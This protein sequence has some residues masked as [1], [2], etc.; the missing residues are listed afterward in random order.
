MYRRRNDKKRRWHKAIIP[1]FN[2]IF[3]HAWR[4]FLSKEANDLLSGTN[5]TTISYDRTGLFP[6]N[7]K[8]DAWE[9]AIGTL[10]IHYK[11]SGKK[12]ECKGWEIQLI[13]LNEG[14]NLLNKTEEMNLLR[15]YCCDDKEGEVESAQASK[16]ILVVAKLRGDGILGRWRAKRDE[17]ICEQKFDEA[18]RLQPNDIQIDDEGDK[19][20]L[21]I[22][23]FVEATSDLP[24]P[25]EITEEEKIQ[26]TTY[27]I[28]NNTSAG[29]GAVWVECLMRSAKSRTDNASCNVCPNVKSSDSQTDKA[30]HPYCCSG[31][32]HCIVKNIPDP[33]KHICP[34]C[35]EALHACCGVPNPD[36]ESDNVG[37]KYSTICMKCAHRNHPE[38]KNTCNEPSSN[39]RSVSSKKGIAFKRPDG[40]W[41]VSISN[42]TPFLTTQE[43][44]LNTKKYFVSS[45]GSTAQSEL[46][47]QQSRK[48]N[49]ERK[50][51]EVKKQKTAKQIAENRRSEW[52]K[53]TYFDIIE[54]AKKGNPW[55]LKKY[56]E[57][58]HKIETPYVCTVGD[59]RV[60]TGGFDKST[61]F[62]TLAGELIS[63]AIRGKEVEKKN[64]L[65][66]EE[67]L[68]A[69]AKQRA[70]MRQARTENTLRGSEGISA[71]RRLTFRL[72]RD[73]TDEK[74]KEI[75]CL[76]KNIHLGEE[77]MAY[78]KNLKCAQ[79]TLTKSNVPVEFEYWVINN[80]VVQEKLKFFL[81]LWFFPSGGGK[82]SK[83]K[84]QQLDALK[85]FNLT[86]TGI[87]CQIVECKKQLEEWKKK[88]KALEPGKDEEEEN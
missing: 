29:N 79:E 78:I 20:A 12:F 30:L 42:E 26:K 63:G 60:A 87:D 7:P 88:H 61:C 9:D 77:V 5:N 4:S 84:V 37:M 25:E 27:N 47:K 75:K 65:S 74:K 1:Y 59:Y 51:E 54:S 21:K 66:E 34:L 41:C 70:K 22:I 17:L 31:P 44:L 16:S 73:Q 40:Q 62:K 64:I 58:V 83:T 56:L 28:L 24:L 72:V 57:H 46:A 35:N 10:G 18:Q 39:N 23:R 36:F 14:R 55:T 86:K 49:R 82:L 6:F 69:Q 13:R 85:K 53:Q 11:L 67:V 45:V 19:A 80:S 8:S 33:N 76:L 38:K 71:E 52:L 43:D 48:R 50:R 2:D 81:R 32:I 68:I 15:G 3:V